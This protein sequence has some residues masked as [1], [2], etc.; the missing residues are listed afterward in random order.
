MRSFIRSS[1]WG[2]GYGSNKWSFLLKPVVYKVPGTAKCNLCKAGLI[3]DLRALSWTNDSHLRT[4]GKDYPPAEG[5]N[6]Q[7]LPAE[8]VT[9]IDKCSPG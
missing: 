3:Y 8:N 1:W 6:R 9:T 4:K 7:A 2:E 5:K